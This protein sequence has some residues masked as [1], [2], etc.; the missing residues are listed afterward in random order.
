MRLCY[1]IVF[2]SC[3]PVRKHVVAKRI[4]KH[5]VRLGLCTDEV[6]ASAVY[7]VIISAL[8]QPEV[9]GHDPNG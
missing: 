8:M 9:G 7:D 3:A 1:Q 5:L 2:T 4:A 6:Q